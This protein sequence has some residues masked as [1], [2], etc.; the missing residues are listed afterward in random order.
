M[1]L[2]GILNA[3]ANVTCQVLQSGIWNEVT[4]H[5]LNTNIDEF[6]TL[7]N[8]ID[9]S[10]QHDDIV[11]GGTELATESTDGLIKQT[12]E[13]VP[14]LGP[15]DNSENTENICKCDARTAFSDI[16][17]NGVEFEF[18]ITFENTDSMMKLSV[19]DA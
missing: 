9:I 14:I 8:G 19:E 16:D 5:P 18:N 1:E 11:I 15:H 7:L 2:I 13:G 12:A 10:I 6:I 4:H 3:M 17:S